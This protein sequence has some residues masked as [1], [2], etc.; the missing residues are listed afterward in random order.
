MHEL[1]QTLFPEDLPSRS[2]TSAAGTKDRVKIVQ[3]L[4]TCLQ[5][6]PPPL[7]LLT[8]RVSILSSHTLSWIILPASS[9]H[10]LCIGCFGSGNSS[11]AGVNS[12]LFANRSTEQGVRFSRGGRFCLLSRHTSSFHFPWWQL[13]SSQEDPIS[14]RRVFVDFF[15][16]PEHLSSSY[17]SWQRRIQARQI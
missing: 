5:N 1:G 13:L 12:T 6:P 11:R 9:V 2:Q 8:P 17:E 7:H 10:S 15:V 16:D 14:V 3:D 4:D